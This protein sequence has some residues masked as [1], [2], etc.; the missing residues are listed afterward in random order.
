MSLKSLLSRLE[1]TF[2][3]TITST[4]YDA[5]KERFTYKVTL[6]GQTF[7]YFMGVGHAKDPPS[8]KRFQVCNE[9]TDNIPKNWRTSYT[10]FCTEFRAHWLAQPGAAPSPDLSDILECLFSDCNAGVLSFEDFVS[11]F[12]YDLDSHSAW[13]THE[14]CRETLR[15]LVAALGF[16]TL[17]KLERAAQDS[18]E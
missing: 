3:Y 16:E 17:A 15:K 1:S 11:E 13:V 2:H 5:A 10:I 7:D 9:Y 18:D 4:G 12:G 14:A 8:G 6:N